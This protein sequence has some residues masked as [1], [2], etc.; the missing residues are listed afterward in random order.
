MVMVV[1]VVVVVFVVMVVLVTLDHRDHKPWAPRWTRRLL[2]L[3][4]RQYRG[5]RGL[6]L[7]VG[8][9]GQ[10]GFGWGQGL[11]GLCPEAFAVTVLQRVL[12]VARG[13]GLVWQVVH[14]L[15]PMSCYAATV[16]HGLQRRVVAVTLSGFATSAAPVIPSASLI[17]SFGGFEEL[18]TPASRFCRVVAI[19]DGLRAP[20]VNNLGFWFVGARAA[21]AL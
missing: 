9:R 8:L 14:I 5:H 11:S 13:L 18:C 4:A 19:A 6:L 7:G 12:V 21:L 1:V 17:G 16:Q 2:S 15:T 3:Q 20:L 10:W